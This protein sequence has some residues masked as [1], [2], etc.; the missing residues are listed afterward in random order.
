LNEIQNIAQQKK[1]P[2]FQNLTSFVKSI[3]EKLASFL[4]NPH[5]KIIQWIDDMVI[6]SKKK[7]KK[8]KEKY[9]NGCFEHLKIYNSLLTNVDISELTRFDRFAL[10]FNIFSNKLSNV[11]VTPLINN[12]VTFLDS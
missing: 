11:D 6:F 1:T 2:L 5:Q 3:D 8:T 9:V 12:L 4:S 7:K 10:W